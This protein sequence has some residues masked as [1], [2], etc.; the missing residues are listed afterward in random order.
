MDTDVEVFKPFD[1]FLN[2]SLFSSIEIHE[3]FESEG[4]PLLNEDFLPKIKGETIPNLGILSA[5]IACEPFNRYI[6]DCLYFYD[7]Q[8]FI[9]EDGS[10]F[11]DII[12]P[13]FLAREAI[14]YGFRYIDKTQKLDDN[15]IIFNSS[16][17][18]GDYKCQTENTYAIH[19]CYGTWRKKIFK[20]RMKW[21]YRHKKWALQKYFNMYI[22]NINHEQ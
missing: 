20:N 5:L 7:N 16:V 6:G 8:S 2:Y 19:F 9:K 3:G 14:K 4:K 15:M 22:K 11:T 12:I 18:A 10:M 21:W 13:D 1:E 17:F